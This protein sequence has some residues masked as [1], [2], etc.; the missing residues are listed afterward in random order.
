MHFNDILKLTTEYPSKWEL[1]ANSALIDSLFNMVSETTMTNNYI[2]RSTEEGKIVSV[3]V[4]GATKEEIKASFK[5]GKLLV[6]LERVASNDSPPYFGR[7]KHE[8]P[9]GKDYLYKN[10]KLENGV[11][12]VYFNLKEEAVPVKIL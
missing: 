1:E 3:L 5:D 6:S 10:A 2:T 12:T 9:I 8:I 4:A 7:L 11:L